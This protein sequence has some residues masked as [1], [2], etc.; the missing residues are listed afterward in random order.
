MIDTPLLYLSGVYLDVKV[1]VGLRGTY[2][3]FI[4]NLCNRSDSSLSERK[5]TLLLLDG[6]SLGS[7]DR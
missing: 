3:G 6:S 2:T 4:G 1:L 5:E 7:G